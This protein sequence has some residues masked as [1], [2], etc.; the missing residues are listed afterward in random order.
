LLD[1]EF[2]GEIDAEP[3]AVRQAFADDERWTASLLA[4]VQFERT[5]DGGKSWEVGSFSRRP[6]GIGGEWQTHAR[7]TSR[8]GGER[9]ALHAHHEKNPWSHP[10]D[11]YRGDGWAAEAGVKVVR[12]WV[13]RQTDFELSE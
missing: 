11:H 9:T 6:L 12:S 3:A 4:S 2:V 8:D 13:R 1:R 10:R 5:P 7:L